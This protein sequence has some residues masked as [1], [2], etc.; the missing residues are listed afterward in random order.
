MF[1]RKYN[2]AWLKTNFIVGDKLGQNSMLAFNL[3]HYF[4][5]FEHKLNCF[6][7]LIHILLHDTFLTVICKGCGWLRDARAVRLWGVLGS[8]LGRL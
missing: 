6:L 5:L 4:G 8:S 1:G 7:H 3:G 2:N